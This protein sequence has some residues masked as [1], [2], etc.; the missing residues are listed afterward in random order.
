VGACACMP[1]QAVQ[2]RMAGACSLGAWCMVQH[3]RWFS[4][5]GRAPTA[6]HACMQVPSG[7][8]TPPGPP[9][10]R[11]VPAAAHAP[12]PPV[13]PPCANGSGDQSVPWCVTC[14]AAGRVLWHCLF[15]PLWMNNG[16]NIRLNEFRL[17]SVFLLLV[18]G[19]VPLPIL[20]SPLLLNLLHRIYPCEWRNE[21][22][23]AMRLRPM[24]GNL[25][26][27]L[28]LAVLAAAQAGLVSAVRRGIRA[29]VGRQEAAGRGG[30][31]LT[32]ARHPGPRFRRI[33]IA[34]A[35]WHPWL[36]AWRG[37]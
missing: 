21:G 3:A 35:G 36:P 11:P 1:C 29:C 16:W 12:A 34:H 19:V 4:L 14:G 25:W 13:R 8:L 17:R 24:G 7:L 18:P 10:C 15:P 28:L 30:W 31:A 37:V 5:C 9:L 22:L 26:P 20:R 6:L 23:S 33:V 2:C 32:P 27:A